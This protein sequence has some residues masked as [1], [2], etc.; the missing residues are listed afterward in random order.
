MTRTIAARDR[1]LIAAKK[2]TSAGMRSVWRRQNV[3]YRFFFTAAGSVL[4]SA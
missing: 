3:R 4:Y 2:N 1:V